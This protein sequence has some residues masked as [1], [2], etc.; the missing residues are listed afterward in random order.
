VDDLTYI[1]TVKIRSRGGI[2]VNH[3]RGRQGLTRL[4]IVD[5]IRVRPLMPKAQHVVVRRKRLRGMSFAC[6]IKVL[7]P[8]YHVPTHEHGLT[9]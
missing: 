6:Q 2:P 1:V 9:F 5:L 8:R 3:K 7:F 4:H